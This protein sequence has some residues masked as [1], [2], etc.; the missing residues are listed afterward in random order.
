MRLIVIALI[1][2]MACGSG[3]SRKQSATQKPG[4]TYDLD[5]PA[6]SL[7]LERE[8]REISG[9]AFLNGKLV[10]VEDEHG[11]FYFIDP[12]SGKTVGKQTFSGDGDFEDL[13]VQGR[14]LWALRADGNLF[15]MD[16]KNEKAE[17]L[18]FDTPLSD[19][20]D[21]EGMWFHSKTKELWLIGKEQ[22]SLNS[23]PVND[24]VVYSFNAEEGEFSEVLR[25]GD[26]EIARTMKEVGAA[27]DREF[28][29]SAI[30]IT[31]IDS[32]ILILSAHAHAILEV[33]MEGEILS[34]SVLPNSLPKG[35]GLA[36][37]RENRLWISSEGEDFGVVQSFNPVADK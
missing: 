35:E 7:T 24:R 15:R 30:A 23:K 1:V 37:D 29:P 32:T 34:G 36:F 31:P 2:S 22:Q 5:N 19:S 26:E 13:A 21:V 9:I 28:K 33:S 17:V 20:N 16:R 18:E 27:M 6:T 12:Q 25:I 10:A 11:I 3:P 8:L 4:F 14:Y